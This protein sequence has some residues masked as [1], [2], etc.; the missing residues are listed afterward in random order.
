VSGNKIQRL[1]GFET[2]VDEHGN[3][4]TAGV[5]SDPINRHRPIDLVERAPLEVVVESTYYTDEDDRNAVT[6]SN[7]R[8]VMVDVRTLGH[9][10]RQ[11][12]WIP[13]LQRTQGLW[14]EDIY[15]PRP[16]KL[17]ID[18]DDLST[19]SAAKGD[20]KP[21]PAESMDGDRGLLFF[22]ENNP[23]KPVFLPYS[24]GHPRTNHPRVKAD[25]RVRRIRHAGVLM[26]WSEDG[27]W[28]LDATAAAKQ[29]LGSSGVEQANNGSGGILTL[30]TKDG[31]GAEL[32]LI[33]DQAGNVELQ[34]GGG[35]EVLSFDKASKQATLEAA[36]KLLL[37]TGS[38]SFE[39]TAAGTATLTAPTSTSVTS[40]SFTLAASA[41]VL[42]TSPLFTVS[43]ATAIQLGDAAP[44][45]LVKHTPWVGNWA[46]ALAEFSKQYTIYDPS[47]P[48]PG[49]VAGQVSVADYF[50]L[51]TQLKALAAAFPTVTTAITKAG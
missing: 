40:P 9:Q 38:T 22:L 36:V 18:G 43:G 32:H 19:G 23:A 25:G 8:T 6:K 21:T 2:M 46:S 37:K 41:S 4:H 47:I 30:K 3:V 33:L 17:D 50:A 35:T 42:V 27:N 1:T 48:G 29:D 11:A 39:L 5:P 51:L 26:E 12:R 14:D 16:T 24:Q 31:G 45:F 44:T 28:T 7:Q 15:I 20:K 13:V 49:V 10:S 34:D